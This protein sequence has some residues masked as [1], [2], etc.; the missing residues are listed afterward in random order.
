MLVTA[1]V[2]AFIPLVLTSAPMTTTRTVSGAESWRT[3][4]WAFRT[5]IILYRPEIGRTLL[6]EYTESASGFLV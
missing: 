1:V 3:S 5:Y 4:L 2:T 6:A